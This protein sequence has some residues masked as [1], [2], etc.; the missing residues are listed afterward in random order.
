L[1]T[2]PNMRN[3]ALVLAADA[4]ENLDGVNV[5]RSVI[6]ECWQLYCTPLTQK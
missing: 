6:R 4:R 2:L 1:D 5:V 3:A